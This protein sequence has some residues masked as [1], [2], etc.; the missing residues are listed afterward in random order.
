[1]IDRTTAPYAAL[2]LRLGL[3]I[4]FLI[5]SLYFKYY[6][7]TLV[8]TANYFEYI[9]LPFGLAYV[10]F[11]IEV[12]AGI[13]LITGYQARWAALAIMP[14]LIGATWVHFTQG[15]IYFA[16]NDGWAYPLFLTLAAFV[17]FLLGSGAY[18]L[19]IPA[20]R[21][22]ECDLRANAPEIDVAN[23]TS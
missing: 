17:Q 3:G 8:A 5:H 16:P 9:G 23:C 14:V 6:L 2:L 18:A 13:S 20:A 21:D 19:R 22:W 12:I 15:W 4:M 7:T 11:W 1:M 10:V